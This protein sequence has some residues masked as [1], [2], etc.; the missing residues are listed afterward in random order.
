MPMSQYSPQDFGG[1]QWQLEVQL[2]QHRLVKSNH[3]DG[4]LPQDGECAPC[5]QAKATCSLKTTEM[6]SDFARK[7]CEILGRNSHCVCFSQAIGPV[8]GEASIRHDALVQQIKIEKWTILRCLNCDFYAYAT[9]SDGKLL[10]NSNLIVSLVQLE[11]ASLTASLFQRDQAQLLNCDKYSMPFKIVLK[12]LS[13]LPPALNRITD[14]A[15]V[16][17]LFDK[18]QNFMESDAK[19]TEADIR[20]LQMEATE[21]RQKAEADFQQLVA[22]IESTQTALEEST[23]MT[24]DELTPPVTPESINDK[25]MTLDQQIPQHQFAGRRDGSSKHLSAINQKRITKAIEF[26]EVFEFDGEQTSETTNLNYSDTEEASDNDTSPTGRSA[27]RVRSGSIHVARS[28]PIQMKFNNHVVHDLDIG[29]DKSPNQPMDIASSIQMLAR[30]IHADSV[31]G[32]LPPRPL[33]RHDTEF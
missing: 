2:K 29:D 8:E 31:F 33:L 28:A 27:S 19:Q 1:R 7:S 11:S 25:M 12:P 15:R 16:K 6:T 17:S 4:R 26:D 18:L 24:T 10:L 3:R 23:K 5:S 32:E 21:R 9:G 22:I 13:A 30:S 14:D 20:R